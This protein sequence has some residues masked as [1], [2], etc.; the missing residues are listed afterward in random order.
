MR[1]RRASVTVIAI[2]LA[3]IWVA[4]CTGGNDQPPTAT[5]TPAMTQSPTPTATE[6]PATP[7]PSIEE[8]V[9]AAYLAYWDAYAEAVLNLDITLV[10]GFAAGDELES[11]RDEIETLRADGV[12][13]RVVVEHDLV[14]AEVSETTAVVVDQLVDNSFYV[15]AE[16]QD[17][18]EG[19]G[20][21]EVHRDIVQLE[22]IDGRWV[23]VAGAR[24]R[25]D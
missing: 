12:A 3:A 11:I 2:A 18:P 23:V 16:T 8:E 1:E 17:P 14:V 20:S 9:A 15:D 5:M 22:Q 10:E 25:G 7:T 24:E 4:G 6:P 19:E 21:G 13:L